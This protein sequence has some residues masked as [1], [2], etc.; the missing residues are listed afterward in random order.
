M[1]V[2]IFA[3]R[4]TQAAPTPGKW[5]RWRCHARMLAHQRH[6]KH[7]IWRL[8]LSIPSLCYF[9]F[10]SDRQGWWFIWLQNKSVRAEKKC[11]SM[12][13][14]W[15][16][17]RQVILTINCCLSN[18]AL[19][20]MHTLGVASIFHI[21]VDLK[22]ELILYPHG[23]FS[24]CQQE[25]IRGKSDVRERSLSFSTYMRWQVPSLSSLEEHSLQEAN[26]AYFLSRFNKGMCPIPVVLWGG[27]VECAKPRVHRH[28]HIPRQFLE[29][30]RTD[31]QRGTVLLVA[32]RPA[33]CLLILP[34]SETFEERGKG[35]RGEGGGVSK[36]CFT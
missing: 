14:S 12:Q 5:T 9:Y 30:I 3:W 4:A 35:G 10:F 18:A 16:N 29:I 2:N 21:T 19:T 1:A 36:T 34:C 17:N 28:H 31:W 8:S 11:G 15:D 6:M 23:E 27:E 22:G 25:P 32:I 26:I 13:G 24:T 7:L 20:R 33:C